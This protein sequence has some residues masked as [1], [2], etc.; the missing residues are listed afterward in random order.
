MYTIQNTGNFLSAK[1][2]INYVT[3][4]YGFQKRLSEL[5]LIQYT[6]DLP[7][8]IVRPCHIYGP[9]SALGC[10]PTHSRDTKLIHRINTGEPLQLVGGGHF[11]QQPVLAKDL[12]DFLLDLQGRK[13]TYGQIL[14]A[15]G[16]DVIESW[17]YYKII[18]DILD[19]DL[20][21]EE[22]SVKPYLAENPNASSFICH[23]FYDLSLAA[24]LGIS[25]PGT[26]IA[27]GLG[28]HVENILR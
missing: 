23:R 9:G 7:W 12:A 25:L 6:G 8:T 17:T 26:P 1:D 24:G 10:L 27:E 13:N 16:P 28:E 19:V 3:E 21:I 18:A 15:A 14:N 11:L 4:G 5:V 2:T 20:K 22:I